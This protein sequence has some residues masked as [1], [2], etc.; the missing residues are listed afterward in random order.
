M[1]RFLMCV[2]LFVSLS[3]YGQQ[4]NLVE[5]YDDKITQDQWTHVAHGKNDNVNVYLSRSSVYDP[6]TK[7]LEAKM[8]IDVRKTTND[9]LKPTLNTAFE[10]QFS[11]VFCNEQVNKVLQVQFLDD[12][13]V[14]IVTRTY[15]NRLPVPLVQGS[16]LEHVCNNLVTGTMI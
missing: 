5:Q 11:V 9:K 16:I 14:P 7:T 10:L 8:L 4:K 15:P 6:K 3:V 12:K 1:K 13:M 2:A